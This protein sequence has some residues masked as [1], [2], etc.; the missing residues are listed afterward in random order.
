M[1]GEQQAA[2]VLQVLLGGGLVLLGRWGRSH[3][4]DLPSPLLDREERALRAASYRRGAA[5]CLGLGIAFL[6]SL[7]LWFAPTKG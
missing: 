6:A 3:A 4:S 5:V 7:L 2:A 1:T